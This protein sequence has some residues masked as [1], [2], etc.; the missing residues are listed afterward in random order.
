MRRFFKIVG[1]LTL[2][3]TALA[4]FGFR[5]LFFD[6][7]EGEFGQVDMI[8]PRDADF[9]VRRTELDRDFN[10]FPMPDFFLGLR[11]KREWREFANTHLYQGWDQQT[12]LAQKFDEFKQNLDQMHPLRPMEDLLAREVAVVGRYRTDGSPALAVVTRASFRVKAAVEALGIGALRNFAKDAVT[13]YQ[14]AEG[15]KTVTAQSGD[16]FH[17]FRRKDLLVVG[18]D[19]DLVREM[20]TLAD[21]AGINITD[22][23]HYRAQMSEATTVGRPLDFGVQVNRAA[24]QLGWSDLHSRTDP[25]SVLSQ[26]LPWEH[27]GLAAGRLALGNEVELNARVAADLA[28]LNSSSGGL[29]AGASAQ[30]QDLYDFC[31]NVF[32]Q[33]VFACAYLRLDI[34]QFLLRLEGFLDGDSRDLLGEFLR[35]ARRRKGGAGTTAAELL[36][37]ASNYIANEVAIALEPQSPYQIPDEDDIRFPNK[38]WGPR[39]ALAFA[40]SD[41]AGLES[42]IE[43]IIDTIKADRQKIGSIFVWSYD[44]RHSFREIE[45]NDPAYPSIALGFLELEGREFLVITT[46]GQFLDEVFQVRLNRDSGVESGLSTQVPFQQAAEM[47]D[48]YGQGFVFCSAAGMRQVLDDLAEVDAENATRPDWVKVRQ[49]VLQEIIRRD[50]P[51]YSRGSIPDSVRRS[52]DLVIDEEMDRRELEWTSEILPEAVE[53]RRRDLSVCELFRWAAMS[54]RVGDRDVGFRLR[55]AS[56]LSFP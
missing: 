11:L 50:Y 12:Q 4:Y 19:V 54:Y 33:N 15:V 21:D 30:M 6:P 8:V 48:G 3:A 17:L 39:V 32:P 29:F 40:V 14:E 22:A 38:E 36:S 51:Q 37:E 24:A 9:V 42:V 43:E 35:H 2:F 53:E 45:F 28:T 1:I 13:D 5:V 52:L 47:V 20:K 16:Q 23:P 27:F 56:S 18:T 34:R 10:P 49:E 44:E 25:P 55:L 46:T 7:F 26:L 41:R 31:G